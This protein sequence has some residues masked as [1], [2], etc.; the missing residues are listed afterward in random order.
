MVH[1]P[2]ASRATPPSGFS[3]LSSPRAARYPAAV[4]A[5]SDS[6]VYTLIAPAFSGVG[7]YQH[8][9]D[10]SLAPKTSSHAGEPLQEYVQDLPNRRSGVGSYHYVEATGSNANGARGG[11][12]HGVGPYAHVG[13]ATRQNRSDHIN[14][15][16]LETLP[17]SHELHQT[18]TV[19]SAG[20][21]MRREA[22]GSQP[23]ARVGNHSKAASEVPKLQLGKVWAGPTGVYTSPRP[24]GGEARDTWEGRQAD[25]DVATGAGEA[26]A[27]RRPS[28]GASATGYR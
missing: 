11:G 3:S 7:S 26:M 19:A 10:G 2:S 21:A 23:R 15:R 27:V 24:D 28:G 14:D 4:A 5:Q 25:R 13:A 20:R 6:E 22:E 8:V 16:L 17:D 9:E 18:R 12:N 1:L